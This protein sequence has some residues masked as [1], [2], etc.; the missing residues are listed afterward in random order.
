M[1]HFLHFPLQVHS[2]EERG[3][4]IVFRLCGGERGGSEDV[5]DTFTVNLWALES[6]DHMTNP[7]CCRTFFSGLQYRSACL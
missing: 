1:L 7:C 2:S 6:G 4:D 5:G 3:S